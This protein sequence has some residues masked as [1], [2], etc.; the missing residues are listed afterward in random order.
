MPKL[1]AHWAVHVHQ[2]LEQPLRLVVAWQQGVE[3][4]RRIALHIGLVRLHSEHGQ[5]YAGK[6]R[7]GA[8]MNFHHRDKGLK[9]RYEYIP[10]KSFVRFPG[11]KE[12]GTKN[13]IVKVAIVP[14]LPLCYS[15]R[16][17]MCESLSWEWGYEISVPAG[18]ETSPTIVER[19]IKWASGG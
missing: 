15:W 9:V 10:V 8:K 18:G 7:L 2:R 5:S 12:C 1:E 6:V 16:D 14:N 17:N 4:L 19:I 3:K 11:V 13:G